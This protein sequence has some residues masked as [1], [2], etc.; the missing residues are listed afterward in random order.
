MKKHAWI[1]VLLLVVLAAAAAVCWWVFGPQGQAGEKTVTVE[2]AHTDGTVNTFVLETE[3]EFLGEAMMEQQLLEGAEG[4]YGL[5]ISS[6]DGEVADGTDNRW[7]VYTRE[8]EY[9]EYGVDQCAIADGDHYE[10]FIQA[11]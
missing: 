1:A 7:W 5:F 8:G 11:F 3:A 2:V 4:Q 6:V 9:V 10:F